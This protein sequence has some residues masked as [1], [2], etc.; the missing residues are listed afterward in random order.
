[1]KPCRKCGI[2]KSLSEFHKASGMRDG[3]RNE[4]KDC[5]RRIQQNAYI[6]N[7]E[8]RIQAAQEWKL[9]NPEKYAEQKR[10][11]QLDPVYRQRKRASDRAGYLRRKYGLSISDYEFLVASQGGLCAICGRADP[12]GL[13]ID[14]AHDSKLIRGLLCGKCNK[15]IGLFDERPELFAEAARYLLR[16]QFSLACGDREPGPTRV[17]RR[18]EQPSPSEGQ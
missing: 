4:C 5:W 1:M 16:E 3:H 8:K 7:R 14:H 15:A 9:R 10:R 17:R 6:R 12:S 11:Y 2:S 13:H 18:T